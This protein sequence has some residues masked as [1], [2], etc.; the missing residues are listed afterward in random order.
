M[1]QSQGLR[2]VTYFLLVFSRCPKDEHTSRDMSE[3]CELELDET[4][5]GTSL[6]HL[7][8]IGV[9]TAPE[10]RTYEQR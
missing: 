5:A 8:P 9:F 4:L 10:R 7:L 1:R 2:W 3:G 6:G